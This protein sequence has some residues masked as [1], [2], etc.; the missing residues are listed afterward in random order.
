MTC[1]MKKAMESRRM[2]NADALGAE[3]KNTAR[4]SGALAMDFELMGP[5][6]CVVNAG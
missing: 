3:T 4:E 5:A 6:S 2:E 1:K